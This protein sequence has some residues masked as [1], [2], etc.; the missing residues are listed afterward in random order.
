MQLVLTNLRGFSCSF[1]LSGCV[2]FWLFSAFQF[3][4]FHFYDHKP[5]SFPASSSINLFSFCFYSSIWW[6]KQSN[7]VVAP[8]VPNMALHQ[9]GPG[10]SAVSLK[11]CCIKPFHTLQSKLQFLVH[12][13]PIRSTPDVSHS[14]W[15][16]FSNLSY[17]RGERRVGP[18]IL[19]LRRPYL[20]GWVDFPTV[21]LRWQGKSSLIRPHYG[22]GFEEFFWML[23]HGKR[24]QTCCHFCESWH[25]TNSS[26]SPSAK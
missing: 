16:F 20:S 11:F 2:Q 15:G 13:P 12:N 23:D 6:L 3:I 21:Q 7:F 5:F 25:H 17:W 24:P 18:C 8:S 4:P 22:L 19:N 9:W 1:V 14:N 26:L 10:V